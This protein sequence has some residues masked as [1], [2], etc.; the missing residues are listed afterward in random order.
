M[1]YSHRRPDGS[2]RQVSDSLM[3][4]FKTKHGRLVYDASG[5]YPDLSTPDKSYNNITYSLVSKMLHFDFA[6]HYRSSHP[7]IPAARKF[8]LTDADYEDFIKFLAGRDYGYITKSEK[9][10][11]ELKTQALKEKYFDEIK[12]E[13]EALERR[14]QENKKD[15]L[16]RYKAEI[17]EV[18]EAEIVARYYFQS[19]KMEASFK[20]DS[21]IKEAV[22][23]LK[24]KKLYAVILKGD[25]PYKTIGKPKSV[26][27]V[28]SDNTAG[29]T[30]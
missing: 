21:S 4:E 10:L 6:T 27:F 11:Q 5:I 16:V 30:H 29:S 22:R 9:N 19:G 20:S 12:S 14:L 2:V 28:K 23:V 25:G 24:D 13:Y 8:E 17:K 15:D 7:V 26:A 1:D 18:L 3:A